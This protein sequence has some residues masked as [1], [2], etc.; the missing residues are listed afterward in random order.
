MNLELDN[1][2]FRT[3]A[4]PEDYLA[5]FNLVYKVFVRTGYTKPGP[6][7]FRLAPQHCHPD[8]RI[9]VGMCKDS[10]KIIYSV[11]IFPDSDKGLPMDMEFREQLDALRSQG[12]FIVEAG[13]LAADPEFKMNTMNIPMLGNKIL[14]QYATQ[15][16]GAD[17][18]VITTHPRHCWVYEDLLLFERIGQISSYSYANDNPAVALRLD[19]RTMKKRYARAYS[20]TVRKNNLYHFFCTEKSA[21][22][23][24]S[25]D[26]FVI[27][28]QLLENIEYLYGFKSQKKQD[29]TFFQAL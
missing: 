15:Y 13:H 19:L 25:D 6:T 11:S 2:I 28:K 8:S 20:G 4:T 9:F 29:D 7:P 12:R 5:A 1:I 18:I 17:D 14:Y 3:A 21:S 24:L 10:G 22:I 23:I 16:L 26:S 27:E